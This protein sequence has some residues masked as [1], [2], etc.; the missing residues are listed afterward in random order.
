MFYGIYR[1]SIDKKGRLI[2]PARFREV[3]RDTSA[4]GEGSDRSS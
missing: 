1:H 3:I 4:I 2:I